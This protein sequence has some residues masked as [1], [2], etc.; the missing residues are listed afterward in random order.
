MSHK[1]LDFERDIP[2]DLMVVGADAFQ[3]RG[4]YLLFI[5]MIGFAAKDLCLPQTD[6]NY[7]DSLNWLSDDT[8]I[9]AWLSMIDASPTVASDIHKAVLE[10]PEEIAEAC[11]IV[12]RNSHADVASL[13]RFM[14]RL[15]V[16][17]CQKNASSLVGFEDI[18]AT[19]T[20]FAP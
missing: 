19:D 10:R 5:E 8:Q 6:P 20:L 17:V 7:I 14:S 12:L 13:D 18:E 11:E 3:E 9:K 15:G 1:K 16:P 2:Q 4:R